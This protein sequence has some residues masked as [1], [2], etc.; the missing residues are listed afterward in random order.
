MFRFYD[1]LDLVSSEQ[2]S[3][4]DFVFYIIQATIVAVGASLSPSLS[5]YRA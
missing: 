2:I 4:I 5:A 1:S 3:S